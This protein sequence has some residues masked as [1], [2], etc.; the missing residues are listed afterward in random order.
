MS[1]F[2]IK[3]S[4]FLSTIQ[5]I[6]RFGY[7]EIGVSQS[8]VL[9]EIAYNYCNKILN[10]AFNSNVL[11]ITYGNFELQSFGDTIFCITGAK[12]D[13]FLN[14]I[15]IKSYKS[16]KI[17]KGDILKIGFVKKG[18]R[19]YLGVKGGFLDKK[20]LNSYSVSIKEDIKKAIK[21]GDKLY[22]NNSYLNI[23]S[24]LKDSY[25]PKYHSHLELRVV[26]GYESELFKRSEIKKFFSSKYKIKAQNRMGYS[27]SGA[28]IEANFEIIS[29]P[30]SF[31]AI[32]ITKSGDPIILLK[33]RQSIGGYPK[34]GS[35]FT[36][37][38]FKLAQLRENQTISFKP[39]SLNIATKKL[40]EFYSFFR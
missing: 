28:K 6:G 27:L 8:G 16:Y 13:I 31:G 11:E 7:G 15:K 21:E 36:I 20:V 37:D 18:V 22:F 35:L 25:I 24:Y 38:C 5:D 26:L 34:I 12:A 9:D 1:Y 32:Q 33:E 3:K 19:L 10:N 29:N 39:I 4:G 23:S 17:K 40:R 30:I 14:N 2:L